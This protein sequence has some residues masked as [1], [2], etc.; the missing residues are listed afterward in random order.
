MHLRVENGRVIEVEPILVGQLWKGLFRMGQRVAAAQVRD[1]QP[2][3]RI[4]PPNLLHLRNVLRVPQ[5]ICLRHV[6]HHHGLSLIQYLQLRV[7]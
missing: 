5:P 7:R 6:Q 4:S 3:A 2:N 1:D